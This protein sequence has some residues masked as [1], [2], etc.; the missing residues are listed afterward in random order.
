MSREMRAEL[1]VLYFALCFIQHLSIH[2][3]KRRNMCGRHSFN[4]LKHVCILCR[5]IVFGS[6]RVLLNRRIPIPESGFFKPS[7]GFSVRHFG[8]KTTFK[9]PPVT[10]YRLSDS[11][12]CLS[13]MRASCG[14]WFWVTQPGVLCGHQAGQICCVR[15]P[16]FLP[17]VRPQMRFHLC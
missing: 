12:T 5:C 10:C 9:I 2:F 6:D 13:S 15:V 16:R 8:W 14:L 3:G 1:L 7:L 4:K 11:N 17:K